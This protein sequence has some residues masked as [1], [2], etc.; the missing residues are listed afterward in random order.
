MHLVTAVLLFTFGIILLGIIFVITL[1]KMSGDAIRSIFFKNSVNVYKNHKGPTNLFGYNTHTKNNSNG[2]SVIIEA[3]IVKD[4]FIED[5]IKNITNTKVEDTDIKNALNGLVK[6]LK[7]IDDFLVDHADKN[8][9]IQLLCDYYIP[10]LLKNINNYYSV[11]KSSIENKNTEEIKHDLLETTNMIIGV[12][13]TIIKEF[14]DN[15]LLNTSASL[16]AIKANI[17]M[18][19]YAK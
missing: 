1:L 14:Y 3:E 19:G 5:Y 12:F 6:I 10:E 15:M 4:T 7:E 18:K 13:S 2:N 8:K 16:D 11:S 17:K 9:D